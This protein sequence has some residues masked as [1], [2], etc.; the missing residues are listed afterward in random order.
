MTDK[1]A[2]FFYHFND[3]VVIF[4]TT[5]R[6]VYVNRACETLLGWNKL[7][8]AHGHLPWLQKDEIEIVRHLLKRVKAGESISN[9]E[10][11]AKRACGDDVP[12]SAAFSPIFD[13]SGNVAYIVCILRDITKQKEMERAFQ[14]SE[15]RFRLI[16]EHSSDYILILSNHGKLMYISPSFQ[17]TFGEIDE[18]DIHQLWNYV[19]EE[20]VP[21]V[22]E[23]FKELYRTHEIQTV[24]F[25]KRNKQGEW[26]WMEA[27]GKA[28]L[29]EKRSL[30]YVIVTAKNISE[31]KKYEEKLRQ[32]AYFDS[33]TGI[34]NRTYFERRIK[35]L[36][37]D[38][39]TFALCYL[40]FD[41][42]KWINDHFS[43]QAGDY[44]LQEAVKRVRSVLRTEDFFAR[45]GGDEFVLLLPNVTKE[46]VTKLADELIQ[47]FH[48]PFYY[49]KQRIQSTLSIGI[50]FFPKDSERIEQV[51]K[52]ADQ[53]LYHVK[54]RGRN[55]YEFYRPAQNRKA[56]IEQDLPF[57]ILQEQLYLCYQPKIEL[58]SGSTM[59]VETLLRWRHPALGEIPPLEFIPLAE[60]SGFIF[61]I[62]LWVLEQACRQVKEW[63]AHFPD[64][65]LAVNLSPFLLNR[66]ELIDHVIHILQD[67]GFAPERLILE[68]TESGLMENIE[69]GKH[70]LTE[71]KNVGIQVAIDDFGTGFSSLA[72]IRNLPVSLLKIDR[73]FIQ[74][75]AENSKDATI[76][77]TIIHLAKSLDIKVLA[78]GV[79]TD[80]QVSLL[81]Q[82]HCDFAQ[83]FYFSKSLEAEKLQQWL[84]AYNQTVFLQEGNH[85]NV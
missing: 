24:E 84:E 38:K 74:G 22:K 71:F 3:A 10:W 15:R 73:S 12:V 85:S 82:M 2:A 65:N 77:D 29:N 43:H 9:V 79:E 54:E 42:F 58:G 20:D 11:K 61:E 66:K 1:F 35:Q 30:D 45:I 63:Q 68:V 83:G 13:E 5:E 28:I 72:Y 6:V 26:I 80:N 37:N 32:L 69:T 49:E 81:Q 51:M 36:V 75:I 59:G 78:E 47:T 62:T 21:V 76:V 44:F 67:T 64:L 19:Y 52:Y 8:M 53:A 60:Q 4:D 23:K 56:M 17:N 14:E 39:T 27:Q 50:A 70:I 7:D 31:R 33:L 48:Q 25:R 55:G 46:D 41:K 40:D 16:A 57:A 34:A 18:G